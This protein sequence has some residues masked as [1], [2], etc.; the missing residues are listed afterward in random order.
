MTFKTI[1]EARQVVSF[2]AMANKKKLKTKKTDIISIGY[3]CYGACPFTLLISKDGKLATFKIKTLNPRHTCGVSFVNPLTT[4]HTLAVYIKDEIQ[5]NSK[6][7]IKDMR[8][9]LEKKI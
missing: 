2:Y 9:I 1:Q 5:N 7:L 3:D 4:C 6:Y 8:R